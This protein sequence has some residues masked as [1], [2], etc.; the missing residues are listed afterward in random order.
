MASSKT[1]PG[2]YF[3]VND[4]SDYNP[5]L[6]TTSLGA[7]GTATRGPLLTPTFCSSVEDFIS[8][9]GEPNGY[10]SYAAV[11]YL[12]QGNQLHYIRIARSYNLSSTL[13]SLGTPT[14]GHYNSITVASGHGM[15]PGDYVELSQ[16]GLSTFRGKIATVDTNLITFTTTFDSVYTTA[17]KVL[18]SIGFAAT[19]Y[20]ETFLVSRSGSA[21][22]PVVHVKAKDPGSWA[23]FGTSKGLEVK[24]EDGG[25]FANL[26]PISGNPVTDNGGYALQGVGTSRPAVDNLTELYALTSSSV[27]TGTMIGVNRVSPLFAI[28]SLAKDT[29]KICL[30]IAGSSALADFAIGTKVTLRGTDYDFADQAVTGVALDGSNTVIK[31]VSDAPDAPTAVV[32]TV[33]NVSVGTEGSAGTKQVETATVVAAGGCTGNGTLT[34]TVSGAGAT[35]VDVALTTASHGTA[36]LI[37]AAIRSALN[38]NSTIVSRYTVGGTGAAVSLTTKAAVA[39]D[40]SLNIAFPAEF[41]VTAVVTSAH[42]IAG[43]AAVPAVIAP[44]L[45]A[46]VFRCAGSDLT[47]SVWTAIGVLTKKITVY[48]KG[49]QVETFENLIGYDSSL[50]YYWD[51]AVESDYITVEYLGTGQQPINSLSTANPYNVRYLLGLSMSVRVSN[52]SSATYGNVYVATGNDGEDPDDSDYVLGMQPF[53]KRE[54]YPLDLIATPGMSNASVI[55]EMM[56]IAEMREDCL[57]LVD[58]PLGMTLQQVVEWHNGQGE[59]SGVHDAFTGSSGALFYPWIRQYDPYTRGQVWVPPSAL[60]APQIAYSDTKG[61]TW[62]APAGITRGTILSAQALE[63]QLEDGDVEFMYGPANG[64]AINPIR[65]YVHDGIVISGQRTLQRFPSSLDRI[66]V[67]RLVSYII[68]SMR[69]SVRRLNFEQNDE[70]LWSQARGIATPFLTNLQGRRAI[71]WYSAICDITNNTAFRRNQNTCRLDVQIVATKSA[72]VI[73]VGLNLFPSGVTVEQI[74]STIA[75]L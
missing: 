64:N 57:A 56:A 60:V 17:A 70:I 7:I 50:P 21:I 27:R 9:F 4:F 31:V 40:S 23:N 48:F 69:S 47:G 36:T 6:A 2:V 63:V 44:S 45:K 12:R 46:L 38:L 29:T 65:Q 19:G 20:A 1:A 72:E 49:R 30:T 41:G 11:N 68:K 26:D 54:A 32:A 5:A 34:V 39:N 37:A 22:V 73:T 62:F 61:E 16:S 13:V 58:P 10:G 24:V 15:A 74:T 35:T 18:Y 71:E 53:R 42:S 55:N 52:S 75:S 33:E 3:E 51:N 8:K 43:V 67:K 59:Y 28:T 66:N 14:N 25:N